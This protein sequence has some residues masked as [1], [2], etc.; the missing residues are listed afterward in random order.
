MKTTS[1]NSQSAHKTKNIHSHKMSAIT[2][3]KETMDLYVVV[4]YNLYKI[5]YTIFFNKIFVTYLH[6]NWWILFGIIIILTAG[7]RFYKVT[8]PQHVW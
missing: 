5:L 4:Y 8:E 2:E 7:T 3:K 6:R 1:N